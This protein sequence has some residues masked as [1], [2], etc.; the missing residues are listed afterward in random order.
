MIIEFFVPPAAGKTTFSQALIGR[1]RAHGS[2][3]GTHAQLPTGPTLAQ[4]RPAPKA[5]SA[6]DARQFTERA[7]RKSVEA[8]AE[9]VCAERER[10]TR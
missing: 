1:L 2:G 5:R 9:Q 7:L 10:T 4:R 3:G 8:V 6:C